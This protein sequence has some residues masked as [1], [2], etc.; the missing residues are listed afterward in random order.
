MSVLYEGNIEERK[1][2][3]KDGSEVKG[4]NKYHH[5]LATLEM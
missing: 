2:G 1:D 5:F 3:K 4:K